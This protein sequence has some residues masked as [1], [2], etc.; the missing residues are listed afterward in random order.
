MVVFAIVRIHLGEF[1]RRL[2][3]LIQT[4]C[5]IPISLLCGADAAGPSLLLRL[6]AARG[7]HLFLD[8]V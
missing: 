4:R 7:A 3:Y 2:D 5:I 8:F 6:A 1:R